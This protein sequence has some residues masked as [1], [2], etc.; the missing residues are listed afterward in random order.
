MTTE[1]FILQK[2]E[3][4]SRTIERDVALEFIEEAKE[5]LNKAQTVLDE[6]IAFAE[7]NGHLKIDVDT[8]EVEADVEEVEETE[9]E[10]ELTTEEVAPEEVV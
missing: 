5:A 7:A 4:R 6:A 1:Q 8:E 3:E 10:D 2:A 9:E